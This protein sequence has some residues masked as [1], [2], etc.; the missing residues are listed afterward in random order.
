MSTKK[1][2]PMKKKY[3][4]KKKGVYKKNYLFD[5]VKL[6]TGPE[7]KWCDT[8]STLTP[9]IG[10]AFVVTPAQLNLITGSVSPQNRIGCKILMRSLKLRANILWPGSQVI[11]APS[12]VRFVVVY[13]RQS[14]GS[15]ATRTDVFQDG[16]QGYSP[17]NL[18]NAERFLVLV[19]EYSEQIASNGQFAVTYECFRKMRLEP[20]YNSLATDGVPRTG[21]LLLFVSTNSDINDN[22]VGH[23]PTVQFWSRVRYTDV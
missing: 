8:V 21:A 22:T 18:S 2:T 5:D 19:D 16:T 9:P 13:D 4:P 20:C 17:I 15:I 1:K 11:S 7:K 6:V 14:N 12:Q 10:S 3:T 23:F